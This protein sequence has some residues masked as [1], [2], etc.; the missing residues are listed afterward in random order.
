MKKVFLSLA[1]LAFVATGA[2]SCSSD[3]G[4]IGGE[5][6]GQND[7]TPGGNVDTPG[8][9]QTPNTVDFNGEAIPLIG[10]Y[11]ELAT[12]N[13]DLVDEDGQTLGEDME[14]P[15]LYINTDGG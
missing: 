7:D 15:I 5:N 10:S 1:A 6:P 9:E 14:A 13:Y 11:F 2:V 12:K 8:E 4:G 3:D